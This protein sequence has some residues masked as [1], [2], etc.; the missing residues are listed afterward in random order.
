[1][2]TACLSSQVFAGMAMYVYVPVAHYVDYA[3]AHV[4][5]VP[6]NGTSVTKV[7]FQD[8]WLRLLQGGQPSS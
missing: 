4:E 1:M 6:D 5:F 3:V 7:S 8:T 2:P